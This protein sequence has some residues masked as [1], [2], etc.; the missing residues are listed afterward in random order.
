MTATH[1]FHA[2]TGDGGGGGSGEGGSMEM[3]GL[4]GGSGE[5]V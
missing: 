5:G 4:H 3:L 2:S 1:D